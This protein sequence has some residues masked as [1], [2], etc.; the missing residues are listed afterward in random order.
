MVAIRIIGIA[1]SASAAA[2]IA[3]FEDVDLICCNIGDPDGTGHG[4]ESLWTVTSRGVPPTL[5]NRLFDNTTALPVLLSLTRLIEL[6]KLAVSRSPFNAPPKLLAVYSV[7][8]FV[9]F[10]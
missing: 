9:E 2:K 4:A 6:S 5:L 3:R 1:R 8:P 7:N 10:G